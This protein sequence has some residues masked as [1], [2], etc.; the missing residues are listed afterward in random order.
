M[1]HEAHLYLEPP[2]QKDVLPVPEEARRHL[3]KV[4]R[5]SEGGPVTYTDGVGGIGTG[6]WLGTDVA[7]GDESIVPRSGAAVDIAVAPPRSKD[8]QRSIVEKCQE[9][10]VRSLTW[11]DSEWGSGRLPTSHKVLAWS[12]GAL[13]Q[14]RGAWL[15]ET[16]GP[17]KVASL[18]L[19]LVADVE[20]LPISD[21]DVTGDLCIAIGPE[22][23]FA[24][25]EVPEAW[26][27]VQLSRSVLRTDTAAIVAAGVLGARRLGW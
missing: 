4:L 14:S 13:E 26:H 3:Q 6:T 9:L 27:R 24:P 2:W 22:G 25:G 5:Y 20:G 7:R 15:L 8:R 17:V 21:L 16:R 12:I 10:D 19:A 1:K 23:G 18:G 11:L